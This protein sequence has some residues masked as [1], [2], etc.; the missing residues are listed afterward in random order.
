MCTL[1]I[2]SYVRSVFRLTMHLLSLIFIFPLLLSKSFLFPAAHQTY[3]RKNDDLGLI[4]RWIVVKFEHPVRNPSP[5]IV[6]VG[7]FDRIFELRE[8]PFAS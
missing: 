2:N 6:T 5:R 1:G 7:N 4:H 8:I 3:L